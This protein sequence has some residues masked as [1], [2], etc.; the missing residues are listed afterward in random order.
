M[1]PFFCLS[2]ALDY[3]SMPENWQLCVD[4]RKNN[5]RETIA[6]LNQERTAFIYCRFNIPCRKVEGSNK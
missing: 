2:V 4:M 5:Q 1:S 6:D 3:S